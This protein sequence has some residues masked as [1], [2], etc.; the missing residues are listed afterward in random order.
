MYRL[1]EGI[2][3]VKRLQ[4]GQVMELLPESSTLLHDCSTLGGNSG[5]CVVDLTTNRAVALHYGG[6]HR[7]ANVAVALWMLGQEPLLREAGV[8]DA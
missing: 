8:T 1:F 4:P 7:H 3:D 6:F 2:F 5:S